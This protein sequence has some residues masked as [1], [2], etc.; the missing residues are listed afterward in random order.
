MSEQVAVKELLEKIKKEGLEE[1]EKEKQQILDD[2][3]KKA[4]EIVSSAKK[5]AEKIIENAKQESERMRKTAEMAISQAGR[6]LLISLRQEIVKLFQKVT[7]KEIKSALSPDTVKEILV[8]IVEK[9]N[10][11]ENFKGL[12]I[13]IGKE[14]LNAIQDALIKS[15]KEEWKNG[16]FLKP[17]ED[18]KAGFKIGIK[19]SNV[20]YD[21]TD[22]GLAEIIG[23]YV[24]PN[25]IKY[26]K[27]EDT[28]N[29]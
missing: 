23:E 16:V 15:L 27:G 2:A 17:V 26:L 18:I 19:D 5:E 4:S 12:E 24:N 25:L 20:Y 3:K 10:P 21:F 7:E 8:K 9:W 6:N 11:S 29:G 1:A 14:E 22:K 13:L 28:G